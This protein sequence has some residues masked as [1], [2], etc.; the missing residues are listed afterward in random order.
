MCV[1]KI[2]RDITNAELGKL[3]IASVPSS[4]ARFPELAISLTISKPPTN[5]PETYSCGKVGQSENFFKPERTLSSVKISKEAKGMSFDF[6][7]S[8]ICREKPHWGA[9]GE[10]FMNSITG[11]AEI[12]NKEG[13]DGSER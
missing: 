9:F 8:V 5:S 11:A 2:D 6:S 10:P 13:I 3:S 12:A 4:D 1:R 7:I